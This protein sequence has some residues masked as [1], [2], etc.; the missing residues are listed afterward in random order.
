MRV[1]PVAF[2]LDD[3]SIVLRE[4]R[5]SA[6][7]THDHPQ[8]IRGAEATALAIFMAREGT[9]MEKIAIEVEQRFGYDLDF[10][11][12]G[13]RPDYRF[14]VS[15]QGTVPPAIQAV[16]E[17]NDYEDALRNAISLGGDADTLA[18]ISGGIAEALFGIPPEWIVREVRKRLADDMLV[19]LRE[20][21]PDVGL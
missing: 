7:C 9:K 10:S 1:S 8:G 16:R 21:Y 13:I 5:K 17:A 4:A 6:A 20:V 18:C 19:L 2:L 12:D 15:C 14:D 11:L 3:E